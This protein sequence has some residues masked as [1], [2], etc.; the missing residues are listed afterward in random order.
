MRINL[1]HTVAV[2]GLAVCSVGSAM[3]TARDFSVKCVRHNCTFDPATSVNKH[4]VAISLEN[5]TSNGI[6]SN[7]ILLGTSKLYFYRSTDTTRVKL[8]TAKFTTWSLNGKTYNYKLEVY[9]ADGTTEESS[10]SFSADGYTKPLDLSTIVITDSF[11]EPVSALNKTKYY[12][13]AEYFHNAIAG[14]SYAKPDTVSA[15]N[16][17]YAIGYSSILPSEATEDTCHTCN[18]STVGADFYVNTIPTISHYSLMRVDPSIG[19]LEVARVAADSDS[20]G[21]YRSYERDSNSDLTV[22]YASV[23]AAE[24][25]ITV[26][27]RDDLRDL[28]PLVETEYYSVVADTLGNI[29]G[30]VRQKL[31]VISAF[32]SS[33]VQQV[34]TKPL[35]DGSTM[36]YKTS[37][38]V[39]G[40]CDDSIM[41]PLGYRVWRVL[42][43]GEK[44]VLDTMSFY[45]TDVVE[46][47]VEDLFV[48]SAIKAGETKN[49][50]YIQRFYARN[51]FNDYEAYVAE[52]RF[53]VQ[54]DNDTPTGITDV[55]ADGSDAQVKAV[56]YVN[57]LGQ[58]SSRPFAGFNIVNTTYTDGHSTQVKKFIR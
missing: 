38:K 57:A 23:P 54:F 9:Y 14:Y 28:G 36:G 27:T 49:V 2:L 22:V 13:S 24:S 55:I 30:G 40:V 56:T 10:S 17:D 51:A 45:P 35:G 33:D 58:S 3:A 41:E 20:A 50:A 21:I 16:A 25:W 19:S 44:L 31:P 46:L 12:Y 47:N 43:S 39:T 6:S 4:E 18:L 42:P 53:S 34:K 37:F 7:D 5:S 48:D 26:P 1:L 29:Y 52:H 8:A 32:L 11:D 15:I